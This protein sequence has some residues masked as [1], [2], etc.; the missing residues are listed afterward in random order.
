[1]KSLDELLSERA[2]AEYHNRLSEALDPETWSVEN[3]DGKLAQVR[4]IAEGVCDVSVAFVQDLLETQLEGKSILWHKVR[5]QFILGEIE[6]LGGLRDQ[7]DS[8]A[9]GINELPIDYDWL[10]HHIQSRYVELNN[11]QEQINQITNPM[12]QVQEL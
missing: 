6:L 12:T 4:T 3:R 1:M 8:L 7:L 10:N 5:E 2:Q 11:L 9:Q